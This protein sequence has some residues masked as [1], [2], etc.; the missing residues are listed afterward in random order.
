MIALQDGTAAEKYDLLALQP[1][2]FVIT[3]TEPPPICTFE[4]VP[5]PTPIFQPKR[6]K[7]KGYQ[8]R[9]GR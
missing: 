2:V 3:C 7:R 4:E 9:K 6:K 8:K 1:K 5:E